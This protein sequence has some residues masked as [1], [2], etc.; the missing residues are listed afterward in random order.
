MDAAD[1]LGFCLYPVLDDSSG[2]SG[3]S[4]SSPPADP[5]E[6]NLERE[7]QKTSTS[8]YAFKPL[9]APRGAISI[10]V[11]FRRVLGLKVRLDSCRESRVDDDGS[12]V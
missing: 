6:H 4:F 1:D 12:L 11:T 3:L 2:G 7:E 9:E 5:D 8:S 10:K